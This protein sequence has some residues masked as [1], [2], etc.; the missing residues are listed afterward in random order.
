MVKTTK[1][2]E[3]DGIRNK[4]MIRN[5]PFNFIENVFFFKYLLSNVGHLYC[6]LIY[7][8]VFLWWNESLSILKQT[9]Q[10]KE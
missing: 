7:L 5:N 9:R 1:A 3:T 6:S 10:S 4:E 2:I 8:S